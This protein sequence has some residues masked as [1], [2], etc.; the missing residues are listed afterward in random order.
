MEIKLGNTIRRLRK[1][2]ELTQEELAT[3]LDVSFQTVSRWERGECYPDITLLPGIAYFFGVRVDDLLGIPWPRTEQTLDEIFA[4]EHEYIEAKRYEEAVDLLR[5]ALRD[6]PGHSAVMSELSIALSLV[7]DE[8]AIAEAIALSERVLESGRGEKV[9][10]TTRANLCT[11]YCQAGD[12]QKAEEL[13]RSLPHIWE[14]RELMLPEIK[15]GEDKTRVL[16]HAVFTALGILCAGIERADADDEHMRAV[17]ELISLG[18]PETGDDKQTARR[19]I[20]AI[21]AF[22]E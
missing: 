14:S 6:F 15:K 3:Y 22:I 2:R 17:R 16:K 10:Y 4:R 12:G 5:G 7:G 19:Q 9:K 18:A 21:E 13:A 20:K 1:E 11:L 8:S